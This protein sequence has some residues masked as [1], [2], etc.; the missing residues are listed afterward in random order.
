MD[1]DG[2]VIEFNPAAERTFGYTRAEAIGKELASL[3]IPPDRRDDHRAGLARYLETDE[4]LILDQRIEMTAMRCDGTT[5]PIELAV[6]AVDSTP[7][8]FTGFIR[9]ITEQKA[10]QQAV[11]ESR[12]RLAFLAEASAL[13]SSSLNYRTVLERFANLVLPSLGDW[14]AVD[15]LEEDGTLRRVAVGHADPAKRVT[16]RKLSGTRPDLTELLALRDVLGSGEAIIAPDGMDACGGNSSDP[17]QRR[18]VAEL[19][20]R[21]AM[22]VPLVARGRTLGAL[23]L[24]STT[25]GRDYSAADLSLAEDVARR[26]ALAVD[27]ARL[28]RERSHVARTLQRSLLPP[29]LP[30][31]PGVD[32]AAR[33]H[34]AGEGNE[35]GGDFYDLFRTG[36]DDW[37]IIIGDVCGKG[38]DAAALTALAR[39]TVRA[40]AMQARKPSR[41]LS[42]LN[43][44]LLA[45]AATRDSMDQRFCTIAYTRLRPAEGGVRITSTSGGHPVPLVVRADGR[46]ENACKVGTLIGVLADPALSDHTVELGPGDLLILYTDGVTEARGTGDVFGEERFRELISGCTGLDATAAAERIE[47]AALE[48]QDGNPRDDIAIITVHVPP[49]SPQ[50]EPPQEELR[51]AFG[52]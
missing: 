35:V 39:Y 44:A 52:E 18:I 26:A 46:V 32:V 17:E 9:D 36:K 16:A 23:T 1:Q 10:A 20:C 43:E 34:A 50:G 37:A 4:S 33:Y 49:G 42:M 3:I 7:P 21:T 51:P 31:I 41:V 48:F 27:N 13:L 29:H 47:R 38:A 30:R 19:G 40:A 11:R 8:M 15:V 28:Y 2:R 5:F 6:T 14:C 25:P 45:D 22:V 24:V 12:E